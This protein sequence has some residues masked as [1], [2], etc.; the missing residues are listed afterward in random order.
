[1]RAIRVVCPSI[2]LLS[3]LALAQQNSVTQEN[4]T[5]RSVSPI[6]SAQTLFGLRGKFAL[7]G[8]FGRDG[9]P[10]PLY[11]GHEDKAQRILHRKLLRANRAMSMTSA[12]ASPIFYT[13]PTYGSGGNYAESVAV[14]DVNGDGK[15]DL[16]VANECADNSCTSSLGVLLGNGDGTFQAA[17]SYSSGAQYASFVAVSDVN[18][19]GKLDLVVT[20]GCVNC[21]SGTVGVL[22]GNGNGT[23]Q[24]AVIYGSG[25]QHATSVAVSDVNGDG[26]PDLVVANE[27]ASSQVRCAIFSGIVGVL[28]GNGDGTFQAPV[29]YLSGGLHAHSVA[30][31]DVNGDGKPDLVVTNECGGSDRSCSNADGTVGVLLGNGDGSFQVAQAV[32]FASG[33]QPDSSVAVSD[34][35]GDA[36]P[37][38]VI[39]HG[40]SSTFCPTNNTVA[41]LLGNGDGSFQSVVQYGSGAQSASSVAISDVNGDGRPDLVVANRCENNIDCANGTVGVLLGNGDGTFRAEVNYGS[42]GQYP[43]SVAVADVNGDGKPDVMAANECADNVCTSGSVSVL[44]GSH[45]GS[46]RAPVNYA[47]GGEYVYSVAVSDVNGDGKPDLLVGNYCDNSTDCPNGTLGVL[48]GN[49]DGTFHA[50]AAHDLGVDVNSIAVADVNGDGTRDL[51]A[52]AGNSVSVLIGRGDGTFQPAV[53]YSA[54][55]CGTAVSVAVSDVNGDGKPDL[56]VANLYNCTINTL[57]TVGVLLGNGDG[58]FQAAVDYSSGAQSATFVAV[59]DVNGDGRLDLLVANQCGVNDCTSGT[60]S[61]LLGNGDGTFQTAVTYGPGGQFSSQVVVADVNRD[62]KPDLLVA[63]ESS[64]AVLLG[65][66]DGTFQAATVTNTPAALDSGFGSLA[67]ADFNGDGKLDVVSGPVGVLLVGNGDGTFQSP[68]ELGAAGS[69]IA[70]ADLNNDGKPDL[71][72]GGTT[73]LLNIAS[74]FRYETTTTLVSSLNPSVSGRSVTFTAIV[75]SSGSGTPT[76]NVKYLNGATLLATVPSVS[77]SARYTTSKLPPGANSITAVY[78]GDSNNNGST[79]GPVNQFVLAATSTTLTSSPNPS[80]YGQ[81]VIFTATVT[82]G[83]GAPPDGEAI[84]FTRGTAVLGTRTLSGG[85]ATLSYSALG[86]G[87]KAV[88]ATYGGDSNFAASISPADNQIVDMASSTTALSS[89]QNPSSFDQPVT[90]TATVFPQFNGTTPTGCITF[91]SGATRL[92]TL[93]LVNGSVSYT[94]TQLALGTESITAVYS[95][96]NSFNTSTSPALSQVVNQASTTTTLGSSLNPS[97]DG[98]SVT[99]T[100][101]VAAQFGGMVTGSITFTDGTIR[102]GS[103]SLSGNVGNYTTTRL[104]PGSHNI[105]AT[106]NASTRYSGSSASLTQTVN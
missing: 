8:Q 17:V 54:G 35:N 77:G 88:K 97:T 58:T 100:A 1:M 22:L 14:A 99:F 42:A 37:D 95:G 92:G 71:V 103:V 34:V 45:G 70:V 74:N 29:T 65:N 4:Q 12:S 67:V 83:I 32:N 75:S 30:V 50:V 56:L 60:V 66:G 41:V 78:E 62:G 38:L 46:F 96:S 15:T 25:G 33:A 48:Q 27:C 79:S 80:T 11:L 7:P 3:A 104:A 18:G 52:V 64:V 101:T 6:S 39:A 93:A 24:T 73:I 69:P 13:A 16:V 72:V 21:V 90:F 9:L 57:G 106:Y 23:F 49:G 36:T 76:G 2:I 91:Y 82:S 87:T 102:L 31:S 81:P 47:S 89:S 85:T 61:V 63:N 43:T 53:S 5:G 10:N 40:C 94:T 28:L 20:N 19:D 105:T 98:Q 44:L 68:M 55:P 26:K 51:V 84:T 59:S 86:V